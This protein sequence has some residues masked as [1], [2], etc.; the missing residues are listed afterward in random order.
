MPSRDLRREMGLEAHDRQ[1]QDM[2]RS[3]GRALPKGLAAKLL[4][5]ADQ[6][7]GPEDIARVVE[8]LM[9][10]QLPAAPKA[11][12]LTEGLRYQV[13]VQCTDEHEQC[14]LLDRFA[15]EGLQ[16]RALIS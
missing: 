7:H 5:K 16:C 10:E 3:V 13:I 11:L 1:I 6:I 4:A 8:R 15:T 14:A 12:A 2:L 9:N